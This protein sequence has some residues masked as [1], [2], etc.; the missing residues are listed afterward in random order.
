MTGAVT[1]MTHSIEN[2]LFSLRGAR[3][4]SNPDSRAWTEPDCF[5][6]L[7]MTAVGKFMRVVC[8]GRATTDDRGCHGDDTQ[9]RKRT[10]LIA[11]SAATKQSRLARVD[12][13]GLLRCARNDGG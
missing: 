1:A 6:A 3:R 8:G 4:R 13:T 7:A 2:V 5:A 12:R 9:Y 11:R 10:F